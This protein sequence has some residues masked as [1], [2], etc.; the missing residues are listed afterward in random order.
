MREPTSPSTIAGEPAIAVL[1]WRD[2]QCVA[3]LLARAFLD[4]PLVI[5]ICDAPAAE[6]QERMRWSF[7]IAVR[8]H[9]LGQQPAWLVVD[10]GGVPQGVVLATRSR[11]SVQ[12]HSDT[13]FTLRGLGHVG[14]R[15]ALHGF[16]AA[17]IIASHAPAEPFT[18]LRTLGVD[19]EYQ[20]RGMGSQLVEQVI[21]ASPPSLPVYL[22]TAKESNLSFYARHGFEPAGVFRCLGVPVWRLLRPAA[23][24]SAPLPR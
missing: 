21:R 10:S 2:E 13:L 16:K 1:R 24:D 4:D 12:P 19:P 15:T 11:L 18:Y 8:S 7:R 17:Q 23:A 14:L 22:E 9:C 3:A 5:A 20:L 6:R